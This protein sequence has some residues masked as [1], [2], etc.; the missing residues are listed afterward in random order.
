MKTLSGASENIPELA[1]VA[2]MHTHS[3]ASGH[4][5]STVNELVLAAAGLGL[6][7][8]ALTDHGPALPG[9][10]PRSH[11][12][13]LRHIPPSI[14]GVRVLRGVPHPGHGW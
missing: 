2:D 6:R 14:A 13:S 8:L 12:G 3:V 9:G 5:Y 10:P 11:F 4:A 7:G 1:I